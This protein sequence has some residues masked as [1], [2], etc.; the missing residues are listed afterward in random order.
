MQDDGL[1]RVANMQV[2]RMGMAELTSFA[3]SNRTFVPVSDGLR[4]SREVKTL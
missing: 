2:R 1:A 3:L 4:Q